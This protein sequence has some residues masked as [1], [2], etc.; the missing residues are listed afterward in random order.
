MGWRAGRQ[1]GSQSISALPA[2]K[3]H[4]FL[5]WPPCSPL[6]TLC[7]LPPPAPLLQEELRPI[8]LRRMK[9]DVE[10]LPEK[11]EVCVCWGVDGSGG[12]GWFW[13]NSVGGRGC[14]A[15]RMLWKHCWTVRTYMGC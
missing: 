9:E 13:V 3:G 2:I 6:S 4:I 14:T 12:C 10:T 7:P 1:A 8:L 11:E 5:Q 15:S